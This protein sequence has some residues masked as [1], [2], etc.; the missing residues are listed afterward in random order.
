MLRLTVSVFPPGK[1]RAFLSLMAIVGGAT[2][3][4]GRQIP[5]TL[6]NYE[7]FPGGPQIIGG[8]LLVFGLWLATRG[9]D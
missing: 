3:F 1:V 8:A 6:V 7:A 5:L 9:D 2:I 4:I